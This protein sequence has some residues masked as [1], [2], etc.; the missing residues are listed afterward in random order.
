MLAPV[1]LATRVLVVGFTQV[2]VV[3]FTQVL[4]VGLT[5]VPVAEHTRVLVVGLTQV[6]VVGAYTGP[7]GGAYTGP[8]GGAYTGPGGGAY[9][10]PGGVGLTQVL[11]EAAMLAQVAITLTNGTALIP[12]VSD[13]GRGQTAPTHRLFAGA[14][15]VPASVTGVCPSWRCGAAPKCL[16]SADG[17]YTDTSA[18]TA[19]PS[20]EAESSR[21]PR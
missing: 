12:T 2:L 11:G 5:Q 6:L 10:G 14:G 17:A 20:S 21:K 19:A 16:G 7:G 3:G 9:T 8:G 4:V 13:E 18:H 15:P 1:G